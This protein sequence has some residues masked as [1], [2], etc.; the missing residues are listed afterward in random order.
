MQLS[1]PQELVR[2]QCWRCAG[3]QTVRPQ[4]THWSRGGSAATTPFR[5]SR[6]TCTG[7]GWS[8]CMQIP[9]VASHG[10]SRC[11]TLKLARA[12]SSSY[13]G[14]FTFSFSFSSSHSLNDLNRSCLMAS[15]TISLALIARLNYYPS[16]TP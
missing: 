16:R 3:L 2:M 7:H 11:C 14:T 5:T 6:L 10:L 4:V 12:I 9:F 13:V 1:D 15:I 8:C